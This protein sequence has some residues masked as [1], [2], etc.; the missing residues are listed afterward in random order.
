MVEKKYIE[1]N[2][3]IEEFESPIWS[4]YMY[5]LTSPLI[6]RSLKKL[7][8]ADVVERKRGYWEPVKCREMFGGDPEA[9]YG[10]GDPI[11][12]H[13]CSNCHGYPQFDDDGNEALTSF[14]PNCGADMGGGEEQ[15]MKTW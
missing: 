5:G 1:L 6:I 13:L 12:C 9:W 14:C 8:T 4:K 10:H 15:C 3:A 7:P 11:A 2:A